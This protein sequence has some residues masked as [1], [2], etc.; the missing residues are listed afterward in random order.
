MG[1]S[2]LDDAID[3]GRAGRRVNHCDGGEDMDRDVLSGVGCGVKCEVRG[4]R[5]DCWFARGRLG[6]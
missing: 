5:R 1:S 2:G 4:A 6:W 3:L